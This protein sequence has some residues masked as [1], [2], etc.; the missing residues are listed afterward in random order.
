MDSNVQF[1]RIFAVL[2]KF[3]NQNNCKIYLSKY[4]AFHIG[5]NR[6][7]VDKSLI[8]KGL[9]WP[10][11]TLKYLGVSIRIKK[12]NHNARTLLESNIV[13][14]LNKTKNTLHLCFSRDLTLMSKITIV[15][16]LIITRMIHKTSILPLIIPK[17]FATKFNKL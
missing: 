14:F 5:S 6:N 13:P 17:T 15:K 11:E 9:K 3:S 16:S 12:Y 7:C 1:S 10:T 4:Q 2:Q 8:D